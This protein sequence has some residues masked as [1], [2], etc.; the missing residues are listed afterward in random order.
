MSDKSGH[1][2]LE[3]GAAQ[4]RLIKIVENVETVI[5]GKRQA[6]ELVLIAVLARG[7]VLL[8]D[9]PGV[10]KTSLIFSVAKSVDCDFKRIQFT[11]DLMPSDVTGFS[12]YNQKTGEFEFR[13]G[14]VMSNIV[15][16]DEI[17]RASAKTQ[18]ALL[19]AMEEK[20]VTVDSVTY[21]LPDPFMVMATQNPIESFGTY[22]LPEAQ[23][24]RFM[25][26]LSMGYPNI[27]EEQL[28][29]RAG[30][31]VRA[32]LHPVVSR[33]DIL[34]LIDMAERVWVNP[35][36]E[37]YIV[38]IVAATRSNSRVS[39]GS[40]PRGSLALSATAKA[41]ALLRGRS[42][43]YPDDVKYL[44]PFVLGH[45]IILSQEAR[46]ERV[47]PNDLIRDIVDGIVAPI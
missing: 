18:S 35:D 37:R 29:V 8:E 24:D 22:P 14:S 17:N 47:A 36:I 5:I 30:R 42:H 43:V 27:D 31:D 40:S 13:A 23:I 9:V 4:E 45:R 10:G 28:I 26:K 32:A 12:I 16:A 46:A 6:V 33:A 44:A 3:L 11:P 7:H 25:L 34:E 1:T 41:L 15:L 20:Q 19:E 38:E 39:L 2:D 21:V